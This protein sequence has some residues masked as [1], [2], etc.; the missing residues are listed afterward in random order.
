VVRVQVGRRAGGKGAGGKESRWEG[1]QVGRRAGG[2]VLL[3]F[4]SP[5]S[6]TIYSCMLPSLLSSLPSFPSF[7]LFSPFHWS[8]QALYPLAIEG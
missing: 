7:P 3:P 4:L 1:E 5:L 8:R 2:K 6:Y